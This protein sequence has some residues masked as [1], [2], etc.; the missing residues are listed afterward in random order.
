VLSDK[1]S[2]AGKDYGSPVAGGK[3]SI[4][5]GGGAGGGGDAF[6]SGPIETK[7]EAEKAEQKPGRW[8]DR[9]DEQLGSPLLQGATNGTVSSYNGGELELRKQKKD[10]DYQQSNGPAATPSPHAAPSAALSPPPMSLPFSGLSLESSLKE[11]ISNDG[12]RQKAANERS[13]YFGQSNGQL[14]DYYGDD[15]TAR[16]IVLAF[17][18]MAVALSFGWA[19]LL[20]IIRHPHRMTPAWTFRRIVVLVA[21]PALVY[22]IGLLIINNIG[23]AGI[24]Q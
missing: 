15:T 24:T 14:A 9:Y 3:V 2:S 20:P 4:M 18:A 13:E 12:T 10:Y 5:T 1:E 16:N 6:K 8:V 17:T 23:G 7:T 11:T 19:I 22:V 21:I